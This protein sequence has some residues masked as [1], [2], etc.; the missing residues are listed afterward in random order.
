M[1]LLILRSGKLFAVKWFFEMLNE[2][3]KVQ[4][5]RKSFSLQRINTVAFITPGAFNIKPFMVV[6]YTTILLASY[7]EFNMAGPCIFFLL[8]LKNFLW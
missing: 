3:K 6:I 8:D 4:S 5:S 2:G 7:S 1:Y